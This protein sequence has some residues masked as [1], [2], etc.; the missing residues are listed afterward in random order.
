[1]LRTGN[2]YVRFIDNSPLLVLINLN[3]PP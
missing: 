1:M 2:N 3:F